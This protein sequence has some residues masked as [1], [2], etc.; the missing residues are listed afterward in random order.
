MPVGCWL[1]SAPHI[2]P[3]CYDICRPHTR[4]LVEG[5]PLPKPVVESALSEVS[6][7]LDLIRSCVLCAEGLVVG[8]Y[9][10][11]KFPRGRWLAAAQV[12]HSDPN[13]AHTST[14]R[15]PLA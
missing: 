3:L 4:C 8:K 7:D 11:F 6:N 15:E 9:Q 14:H 10:V 5:L 13:W 2:S 12:R 1:V